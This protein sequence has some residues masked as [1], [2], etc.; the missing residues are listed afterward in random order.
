MQV[1]QMNLYLYMFRSPMQFVWSLN[2]H[3]VD[4]IWRQQ[5]HGGQGA[6]SCT[7]AFLGLG[8]AVCSDLSWT[9]V[10]FLPSVTLSF[11]PIQ[12]LSFLL[13]HYYPSIDLAMKHQCAETF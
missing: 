13:S 1:K 5:K 8:I 3:L 9:T 7:D 2:L 10:L 6:W 12:C 11:G 4:R